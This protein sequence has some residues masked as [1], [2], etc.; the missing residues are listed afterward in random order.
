MKQLS[1]FFLYVG[2]VDESTLMDWAFT[3]IFTEEL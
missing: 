2:Y 1:S 3:S